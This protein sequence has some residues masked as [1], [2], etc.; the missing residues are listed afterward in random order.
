[1]HHRCRQP[2]CPLCRDISARPENPPIIHA[3]RDEL[4]AVS[5]GLFMGPRMIHAP[6]K[7]RLLLV[8]A[9]DSRP[10]QVS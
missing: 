7:P 10:A 6:G 4:R 1:V 2:W 9:Y 3:L 5:P 8:F